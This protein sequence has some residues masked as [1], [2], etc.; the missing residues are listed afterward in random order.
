MGGRPTSI[1]SAVMG[2]VLK[3]P[4]IQ[5][6]AKF[7]LREWGIDRPRRR[8]IS[9]SRLHREAGAKDK[10]DEVADIL[11][12]GPLAEEERERSNRR[13]IVALALSSESKLLR[14]VSGQARRGVCMSS[15]VG[16]RAP[17]VL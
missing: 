1:S 2:V 12:V 15:P 11:R 7:R 17:S 6:A 10:L 5:C 4:G 16:S 3:A 9:R 13:A 14:C 8:R